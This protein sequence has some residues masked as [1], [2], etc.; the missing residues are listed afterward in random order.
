MEVGVQETA[1]TRKHECKEWRREK[2][3]D[4]IKRG[5]GQVPLCYFTN[6]ISS[7]SHQSEQWCSPTP[8]RHGQVRCLNNPENPLLFSLY[9][10]YL[11][12]LSN[13]LKNPGSTTQ[14][15]LSETTPSARLPPRLPASGHDAPHRTARFARL[16]AGG[17]EERLTTW[18]N[19]WSAG[20]YGPRCRSGQAARGRR[21]PP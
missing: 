13:D 19:K 3:E 15:S 11:L 14:G 16:W 9:N 7:S 10:G 20:N 17:A 2:T 18:W 21:R 6:P 1:E 12:F 5:Q 8:D 4:T